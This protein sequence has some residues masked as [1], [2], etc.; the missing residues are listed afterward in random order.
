MIIPAKNE[1]R[2]LPRLLTSLSRQDYPHLSATKVY[3]ADAGSSDGTPGIALSFAHRLQVEVVA[4][5]LPAVGRNAGARLAQTPYLLFMDA[6]IG[7]PDP[8]LL[9]RAME[10][11]R[12]RQ[13]HCLTTNIACPCGGMADRL[14]FALN[15]AVQ[16]ASRWV[17]PFATGMFMLFDKQ[18]FD[19][20]G[21]FNERALYAEDYLLSKQVARRRFAVLRGEITTSNRRFRKMGH[22]RIAG[23]FLRTALNTRNA[24]YFLRD[25]GYWDAPIPTTSGA[26]PSHS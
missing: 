8:S 22:A 12:R 23:M 11:M 7:L 21:G 24:N 9:R 5:G 17:A 14:L 6:D 13:L 15:N 10:T 2:D 16:R 1:S 25:Q 26:P 3:V 18:E 4:G 19:R 20:L